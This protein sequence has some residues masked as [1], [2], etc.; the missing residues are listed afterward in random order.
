MLLYL[1]LFL[2]ICFP[3]LLLNG[4]WFLV[5]LF[6]KT[7]VIAVGVGCVIVTLVPLFYFLLWW[8]VVPSV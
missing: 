7:V 6:K 4:E 8:A 5:H 1:F 3:V 2:G